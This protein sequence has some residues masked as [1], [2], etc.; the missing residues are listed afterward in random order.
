VVGSPV[1]KV[2]HLFLP[3]AALDGL[4]LIAL[5]VWIR[6]PAPGATSFFGRWLGKVLLLLGLGAAVVIFLFAT[7]AVVPAL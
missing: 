7:C 2:A 1:E 4:A 6:P 5:A 3:F